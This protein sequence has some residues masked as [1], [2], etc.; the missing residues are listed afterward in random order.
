MPYM[1]RA[2]DTLPSPERD[3]ISVQP[4]SPATSSTSVYPHLQSVEQLILER[5]DS[6]LESGNATPDRAP[7]RPK[8]GRSSHGLR[9]VHQDQLSASLVCFL[10]HVKLRK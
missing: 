2:K 1:D 9:T 4:E 5:H 8:T 7:L 10:V 3:N 6:D